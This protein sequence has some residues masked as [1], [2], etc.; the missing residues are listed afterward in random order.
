[1]YFTVYIVRYIGYAHKIYIALPFTPL[2]NVCTPLHN[3]CTPLHNVCTPL[4][5]VCT[6]LHNVCT[7]L[8]NVCTPLHNVCTPLHNV[9]TPLHNV[10]TPLSPTR[11][12]AH[13]PPPP[14]RP[15]L[16]WST[17]RRERSF[18]RITDVKSTILVIGWE[19]LFLSW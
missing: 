8:H 5:N 7:P 1:M 16:E 15:R 18:F 12:L 13:T 14:P 17:C 11:S 4:H 3:V 19:G 9:C 10:C 2:H 6:P